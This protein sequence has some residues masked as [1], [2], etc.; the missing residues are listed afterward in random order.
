MQ[1]LETGPL[2]SPGR[3]RTSVALRPMKST[4]TLIAAAAITLASTGAIAQ[5]ANKAPREV[6]KEELRA[7]MN[8]ESSIKARRAE[9]ETR[10]TA[11]GAE[12]AAIKEEARKL[13]ED[14]K[15]LDQNNERRVREFKRRVTEYNA[16][17]KA[18]NDVQAG[19]RG[20]LEVLSKSIDRYNDSCA[21]IS[22][23]QK[24]KDEILKEREAAAKK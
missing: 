10:R 7:C 22:F 21:V 2:R 15:N 17:V 24:D 4:T 6:N 14:E 16:R 3:S 19:I 8:D 11:N 9:I 12:H 18:A 1:A 5:A 13:T 20:E 23:N